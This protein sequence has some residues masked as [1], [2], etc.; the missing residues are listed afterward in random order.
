MR[1]IGL[2]LAGAVAA[3]AAAND[4][5]FIRNADVY[6][7]TAPEMK[8]VNL[9]VQDG[10]IAEIGAK[11]AAPKGVR[12]IEGKG[13]RVYPGMIDSGTELGLSEVSAV[14][15]TV[16]TGEIGEF[17]P[18]LRALVAVNPESEHF[19][20]VRANGITSVMTY[21]ASGG[22]GGRGGGGGQIIAGQAALIHMAGWTWEDMEIN[23]S[24][25]VQINFPAIA[26]RGGRGGGN[27]DF[28]D[29]LA[30]LFGAGAP[31]TF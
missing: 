13:L 23:R 19:P 6:P 7:V 24:A 11:L 4:T 21:P 12:V 31:S 14:R 15:E 25:A 3:F 2:L 16:D 29:E 18:Q 10:K 5:F 20:V 30:A 28:P 8:G 9:L 27:P 22:R 17:M 1:L 26:G